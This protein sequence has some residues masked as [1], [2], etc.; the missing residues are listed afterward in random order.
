MRKRF[1]MIHGFVRLR[2]FFRCGLCSHGFARVFKP[3]HLCF[4][5][6]AINVPFTHA[7]S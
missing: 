6:G 1:E 3:G 5:E 2:C 4:S 7:S